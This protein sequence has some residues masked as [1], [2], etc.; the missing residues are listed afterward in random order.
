MYIQILVS[1]LVS[2]VTA[3][4]I[5]PW[6]LKSCYKHNIFDTLNDRKVHRNNVPRLGGVVFVPSMILGLIAGLAVLKV[7]D[8]TGLQFIHTTTFIVGGGTVIIYLVGIFDDL[9]GVSARVKFIIQLLVA[10]SF[11]YCTL[12]INNLYGFCGVY[13]IPFWAMYVLTAFVV[14][15]IINAIN[16]IDG[17]DGLSTSLSLTAL[18]IFGWHYSQTCQQPVFLI[19]I[20]ALAGA[21]LAFLPFNL[22]GKAEKGTKSFMGDSGSLML[23]VTLSYLTIKY[24]MDTPKTLLPHRDDGMVVAI[25]AVLVP[26]FDLCRVALCR[27]RRGVGVFHADK[28]HLHHKFMAKGFSMHATLVIIVGL[29]LAFYALNMGLYHLGARIDVTLLVDVVLFT[30]LNVWLPVKDVTIKK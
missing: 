22:F 3:L 2:M 11:P 17:I 16:L 18:A 5:M 15:L 8:G 21:L 28:T 30:C 6:L 19:F 9:W 26:C 29:Q 23:G 25:S 10:L 4:I 12:N 14:L 1:L 20:A 13:E 24:C 27:L 7:G